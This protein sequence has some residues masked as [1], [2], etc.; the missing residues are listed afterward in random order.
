[1]NSYGAKLTEFPFHPHLLAARTEA[2][3]PD[4]VDTPQDVAAKERF[5]R[6]RGLQSFKTSPWDVNENL[7]KEYTKICQFQNYRHT[8]K[9]AVVKDAVDGPMFIPVSSCK[10]LLSFNF[11][12]IRRKPNVNYLSIYQ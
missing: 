5:Q 1:M 4:W 11:P 8:Y 10:A 2:E 9:M 3:F 7:P 6:Y 12:L